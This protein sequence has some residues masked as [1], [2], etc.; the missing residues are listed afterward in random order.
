MCDPVVDEAGEAAAIPPPVRVDGQRPVVEDRVVALPARVVTIII[1]E[2]LSRKRRFMDRDLPAGSGL[3]I[4]SPGLFFLSYFLVRV[5]FKFQN[6]SN[7]FRFCYLSVF[8]ISFQCQ[9]GST[10]H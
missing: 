6:W 4:R 1:I 5:Y 3:K 8:C 10:A 2:K 7:E 9:I